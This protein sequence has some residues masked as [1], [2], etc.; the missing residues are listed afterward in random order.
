MVHADS[1]QVFRRPHRVRLIPNVAE[2]GVDVLDVVGL[3]GLSF[4]EQD[5]GAR[6][7]LTGW[8]T[9]ALYTDNISM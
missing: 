8:S 2:G 3:E 5:V 7:T 1:P 4:S 6:L 9:S